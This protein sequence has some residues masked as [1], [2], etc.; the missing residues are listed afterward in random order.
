MGRRWALTYPA[1]PISLNASYGHNRFERTAH[2]IEWRNAFWLLAKEAKIPPLDAIEVIVHCGMSGRLQDIGNS[3]VSAKAGVDGL[4]QARVIA[5]D[6]GVH[7]RLLSFTPPVRIKPKDR[8]YMTLVVTEVEDV[9][10]VQDG[11]G[12]V[13]EERG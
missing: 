2:V 3:Y 5:D 12:A 1:R 11:E 13:P 10:N 9:S 7:L 4:V 6:T 8:D